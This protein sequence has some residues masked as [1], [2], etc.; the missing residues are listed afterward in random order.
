[1]RQLAEALAVCGQTQ[2][3]VGW[4]VDRLVSRGLVDL[5]SRGAKAPDGPTLETATQGVATAQIE[6]DFVR[7][8]FLPSHGADRR[9][10]GSPLREALFRVVA[11]RRLL[12]GLS[13]RAG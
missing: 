7:L 12:A 3:M 13:R 4:A 2:E 8:Q 10:I 6:L 11:A 5:V 1:M 9:M